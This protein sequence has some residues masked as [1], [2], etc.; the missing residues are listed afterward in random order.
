MSALSGRFG[1]RVLRHSKGYV[2]VELVPAL[3]AI[4]KVSKE[5][6]DAVAWVGGARKIAIDEETVSRWSRGQKGDE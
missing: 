6:P 3:A 4:A 2:L 5:I 1:A